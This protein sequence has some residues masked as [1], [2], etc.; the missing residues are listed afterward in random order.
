MTGVRW[1]HF[2]RPWT[3]E[4]KPDLT[5]SSLAGKSRAEALHV[6]FSTKHPSP[7][8]CHAAAAAADAAAA[9]V[10]VLSYDT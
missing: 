5:D 1:V 6:Y 2:A 10:C 7:T 9:A 3:Q 8:L 4:S